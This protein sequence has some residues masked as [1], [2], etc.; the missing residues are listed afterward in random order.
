MSHIFQWKVKRQA[1]VKIIFLIL[2]LVG[3]ALVGDEGHPESEG[4]S[5][6]GAIIDNRS[7]HV[8]RAKKTK[9]SY[10]LFLKKLFLA[11][12][13]NG[14]PRISPDTFPRIAIKIKTEL[15]PGL[16]PSPMLVRA[17]IELLYARGYRPDQV[18]IVDRDKLS[19]IRAG[20][21][22]NQSGEGFYRGHPIISSSH[23]DYF[24]QDWIHDSPMPPTVHDRAKLFLQYPQDRSVR[25]EEERKSYLPSILFF[26]GCALDKC[27]GGVRSGEPWHRWCQRQCVYWIDF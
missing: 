27:G 12:E 26:E 4:D 23:P 7:M 20:Y 14:G 16:H 13:N 25:L 1:M 22:S 5:D 24:N 17:L 21:L 19:L 18:L 15:A 6:Q 3:N 10:L 8:Y 2:A 11:S 9:E